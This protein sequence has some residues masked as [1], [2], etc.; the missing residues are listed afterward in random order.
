MIKIVGI[1]SKG[2][3]WLQPSVKLLIVFIRVWLR[4]HLVFF[5]FAF[6]MRYF[7]SY[8]QHI[9][10]ANS[11]EAART[12]ENIAVVKSDISSAPETQQNMGKGQRKKRQ[13]KRFMPDVSHDSNSDDSSVGVYGLTQPEFPCVP[14]GLAKNAVEHSRV[15]DGPTHLVQQRLQLSQSL[16][17]NS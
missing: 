9:Y 1:P 11:Y 4:G 12:R 3:M 7:N 10:C 5:F 16:Y 15:V 17:G 8:P 13:T 14:A 2:G 6:L